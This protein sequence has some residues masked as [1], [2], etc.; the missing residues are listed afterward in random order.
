MIVISLQNNGRQSV[1]EAPVVRN[2][3]TAAVLVGLAG[4]VAAWDWS[5]SPSMN[6]QH[7]WLQ[8]RADRTDLG[9]ANAVRRA[10]FALT[11][12]YGKAVELKAE[13]DAKATA[14]TDAFAR[15]NLGGGHALRAGQFKVPIYLDELTSDRVTLFMEQAAPTAFAVGRRLGFDYTYVAPRW[16]VA[17]MAFGQN[18]QGL[19]E[20]EGYAVRGTW[21]PLQSEGGF[22]H[23]GAAV[24][25]ESPDAGSARFSVRPEA[26]LAAGR[27]VDSGTLRDVDRI[28]RF[29]LEAAWVHG[30]WLLQSEYI[31][32]D[33]DRAAGDFRGQGWYAQAGWLPFGQSRGYKNGVIDAP[34]GDGSGPVVELGL[35]WS[36]LDL[37]DG[38]VAGGTQSALGTGVTWWLKGETRLMANY[39]RLDI[40]RRGVSEK[41]NLLEFRVQLAF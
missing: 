1:I 35:R 24:A 28:D 7:D 14:W 30:P 23:L 39:I 41:P 10:R 3:L 6:L 17:A 25:T 29:G 13:Y 20:G 12:R 31:T 34:K 9:D 22:L 33:V 2:A 32:A 38:T 15:W 4:P 27:L 19:N 5:L 40:D 37:D 8:Y 16:T 11:A 21:L 26:G 36:R 18:L